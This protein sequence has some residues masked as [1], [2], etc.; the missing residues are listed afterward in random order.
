MKAIT[1]Q[2]LKSFAVLGIS[3]ALI[4]FLMEPLIGNEF[5][6]YK[7]I[8]TSIFFGLAMSIVFIALQVYRLNQMGVTELSKENIS[9]VQKRIFLSNLT[10][11]KVVER[12]NIDPVCSKMKIRKTDT[13]LKLST[14][15]S[16]KSWG[17]NIYV[18]ITPDEDNK[19]KISVISKPKIKTTIVDLGKNLEN[20]NLLS[21]ILVS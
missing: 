19:I 6:L 12:I 9:V 15:M 4:M 8:K 17:E 21:K 5:D 18:D 16:M 3:Y 1:I 7:I 11:A 2:F 20:V 13:G 10:K 14:R